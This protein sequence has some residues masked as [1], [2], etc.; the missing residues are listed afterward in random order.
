LPKFEQ[1]YDELKRK[2][3]RSQEETYTMTT[4]GALIDYLH[5][6]YKSTIAT[7][8]RLTSHGEITFELVNMLM[9]PR[10]TLV[11]TCPVTG[12]PRALEL[13]SV[14]KVRT[15]AGFFYDM[16][17]E[18]V[19]AIDD[20]GSDAWTPE[21]SVATEV[22]RANAGQAFGR[23][24]SRLIIAPFAGAIRVN[25]LDA[26]PIQFHSSEKELRARLVARGR[27]WAGLRGIHH[28]TYKG[29]AAFAIGEGSCKKYA[30]Y[31]VRRCWC[32]CICLFG[33][34]YRHRV[35]ELADHDRPW[36]L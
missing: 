36:K 8:R 4:T 19:D 34:H 18:S 10:S 29:T 26:Y 5:K 21:H 3:N 24:R 27:K 35:A 6:D 11:T 2:K 20:N 28:M 30:K 16:L 7:F 13:V 23:V 17:C 31:N 22:R 12:E 1:Y 33:P 15:M 25:T 9:V 14:T 32:L